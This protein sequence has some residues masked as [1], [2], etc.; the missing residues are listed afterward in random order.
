MSHDDN[1][2]EDFTNDD[3]I[4]QLYDLSK[5]ECNPPAA[6]DALILMQARD[7]ACADVE[8]VERPEKKVVELTPAASHRKRWF[9]PNSLAAC[10]VVS[11]MVGLVYRENADQISVYDDYE[12]D[13]AP[14]YTPVKAYLSE[15]RAIQKLEQEKKSVPLLAPSVAM[16]VKQ[17]RPAKLK[18]K[19]SPLKRERSVIKP[20]TILAE[21]AA[22]DIM[23]VMEDIKDTGEIKEADSAEVQSP[24]T[25]TP[26]KKS[27]MKSAGR[28]AEQVTVSTPAP[29]K[30]ALE[31]L[32]GQIRE[33][34]DAGKI[35]QAIKTKQRLILKYPDALLP[36]DIVQ[37]T[38]N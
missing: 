36:E 30:N 25:R 11:V 22:M 32:I 10:L 8:A 14:D 7:A 31:L 34:R 28:M 6:L 3:V 21:P 16:P 24:V 18:A 26:L 20:Q 35:E 13:Y 9:V 19:K 5:N 37:L 23:E 1:S 15:D 38:K 29:E 33:L 4:V 27:L 12:V 2:D 17:S